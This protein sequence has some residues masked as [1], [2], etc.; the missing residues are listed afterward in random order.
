MSRKLLATASSV[1]RS[2]AGS[3]NCNPP[4]TL[5]YASQP[6]TL[7]PPRFSSTAS[8]SMARL[9]SIPLE[10][11][12]A[13]PYPDCATSAWISARMGLEPSMTQV[14]QVPGVFIG[15]PESR[16]SDGFGTSFRPVSAISNTPISFVE[17]KRFFAARRM[18]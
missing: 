1:A 4:T 18:R 15:R 17:P 13:E 5:M 11:R 9:Y 8:S 2:A 14:T 7:I 16:V 10:L 12:R 6:D 3:S